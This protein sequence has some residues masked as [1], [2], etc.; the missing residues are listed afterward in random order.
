MGETIAKFLGMGSQAPA[1]PAA[2]PGVSTPGATPAVPTPEKQGWGS[3]PWAMIG[4][5][6]AAGVLSAASAPLARGVH[7]AAQIG[8]VMQ[9]DPYGLKASSQQQKQMA[10][11]QALADKQAADVV[12]QNPEQYGFTPENV[13]GFTDKR[14]MDVVADQ[15]KAKHSLVPGVGYTEFPAFG[16][17]PKVLMPEQMR[18]GQLAGDIYRGLAALRKDTSKPLDSYT[19]AEIQEAIEANEAILQGRAKAGASGAAAGRIDVYTD[20]GYRPPGTGGGKE[21]PPNMDSFK[22]MLSDAATDPTEKAQIEKLD[23]KTLNAMYKVQYG[24]SLKEPEKTAKIERDEA[25]AIKKD[26]EKNIKTNPDYLKVVSDPVKRGEMLQKE[27]DRLTKKKTGTTGG[28]TEPSA[29]TIVPTPKGFP[30]GTVKV[31]K[32]KD[33][34]IVYQTPDGSLGT[35]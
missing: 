2:T 1:T 30:E 32:T 16:G 20:R 17:K 10:N 12:R 24:F 19:P 18:P 26:A 35:E 23:N 5:P 27:M 21:A 31:G 29:E 15:A 8:S 3:S 25:K 33:G 28:G 22:K 14:I 9:R 11:Q 4:I 6:A 34:K 13:K 7:G